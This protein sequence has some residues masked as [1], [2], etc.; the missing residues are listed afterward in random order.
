MDSHPQTKPK[1]LDLDSHETVPLKQSAP[2]IAGFGESSDLHTFQRVKWRLKTALLQCYRNS[3]TT[4]PRVHTIAPMITFPLEPSIRQRSKPRLSLMLRYLMS[5]NPS[6]KRPS[7]YLVGQSLL[8]APNV[9]G[10]KKCVFNIKLFSSH[11][12]P[13]SASQTRTG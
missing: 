11:I 10:Q 1:F 6:Q 8:T 3:T 7:C 5:R 12:L 9:W 4:G 13:A 2:L